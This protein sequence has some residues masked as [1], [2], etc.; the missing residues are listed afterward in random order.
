M[1]GGHRVRRTRRGPAADQALLAS[2]VH[3]PGANH[4]VI[5]HQPTA[6]Q[7]SDGSSRAADAPFANVGGRVFLIDC[8]MSHGMDGALGAVLDIDEIGGQPRATTVFANGASQILF[9]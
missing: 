7:F 4:P 9:R 5:G 8:G 6:A 2:Y 1:V 3:A